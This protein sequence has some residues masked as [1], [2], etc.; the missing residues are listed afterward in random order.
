MTNPDLKPTYTNPDSLDT[1]I[2]HFL[3][4]KR[5]ESLSPYTLRFYMQQLS[6]LQSYCQ[7]K[8]IKQVTQLT[9]TILRDFLESH[10]AS[11]H[12]PGGLHAVFRVIRTF[13]IWYGRELD[14]PGWRNPIS[15]IKPPKLIQD[16]LPP[17]EIDTIEAM[18]KTCKRGDFCGDRDRAVILC[19]LDTGARAR[20]FLSIQINQVNLIS[21]EVQIIHGKGGKSRSVFLGQASRRA[22]RAYLRHRTDHD[23]ALWVSIDRVPLMYGGLRE[24]IIRHAEQAQVTPIPSLHSF[25]RA[26]ALTMLRNGCDLVTLAR[27]MGHSDYETLQRY[28]KQLPEDLQAAH[29]RASPVD[30]WKL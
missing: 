15:T 1:F 4:A 7:D 13:L 8:Q 5:L 30:R 26:F 6:H 17:V 25:R 28:L 16:P 11:G 23:P 18:L 19:L 14:D 24:L 20:E 12:N 21:G 2:L 22:L 3:Q 10:I 27:L 9:S 29:N